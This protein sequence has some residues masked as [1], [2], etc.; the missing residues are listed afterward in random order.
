M[1]R[2]ALQYQRLCGGVLA[3]HEED[4]TLSRGGSMHEG[5]VS[6][7]LGL[8][9]IPTVSESTMVA[10][11]AALAGYEDARVHFQ[12]LSCAASVDAVGRRPR[13]AAS[14]SARRSRPITCCSPSRTC[15][16]WTRA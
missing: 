14:R 3:L 15:A 12:H 16:G 5:A 8:A 1:L 2:K 9:G 13:R 11:D 7:A 4:E 6:A 10:R